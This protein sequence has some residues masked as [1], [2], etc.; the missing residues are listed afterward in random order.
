MRR[1][2]VLMALPAVMLCS[3][4]AKSTQPDTVPECYTTDIEIT[5]GGREYSATM[6]KS[7]EGWEYEFSAP[8]SVNG[9]KLSKNTDSFTAEIEK[10]QLTDDLQKLGE[11]SPARLIAD[12]LDM[13]RSGKGITAE[14]KD[15]KT[16]NKGVVGGADFTVTFDD[17]LPCSM[18]IGGE[19]A[20][21][22]HDFRAE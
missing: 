6:H 4:A 22:F 13:C 18:E 5:A 1:Y 9:L 11:S 21:T 10:L 17:S 2:L 8:E 16:V 19:I 14:I 20:V 12:A 7:E 3:C 15:G